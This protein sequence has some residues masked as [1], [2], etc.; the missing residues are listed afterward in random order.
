MNTQLTRSESSD[1]RTSDFN[2][3]VLINF[4][5]RT[6]VDTLVMN[7][8]ELYK[9]MQ[10]EHRHGLYANNIQEIQYD[11]MSIAVLDSVEC[12][13]Y[14]ETIDTVEGVFDEYS[15]DEEFSIL[16]DTDGSLLRA[17]KE[18]IRANFPDEALK[19]TYDYHKHGLFSPCTVYVIMGIPI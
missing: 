2:I 14:E 11:N 6:A 18:A 1:S 4:R 7:D 17:V 15:S 16:T 19:V 3:V 8:P 13:D 10:Q 5:D 12:F 9:L